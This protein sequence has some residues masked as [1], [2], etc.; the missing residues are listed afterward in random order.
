MTE[1]AAINVSWRRTCVSCIVSFFLFPIE[2]FVLEENEDQGADRNLH[3]SMGRGQ[4][5]KWPSDIRRGLVFPSDHRSTK[6]SGLTCQVAA[7]RVTLNPAVAQQNQCLFTRVLEE[8][9]LYMRDQGQ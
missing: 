4:G 6:D 8:L 3:G 7:V 9:A 2:F 5:Y 1:R